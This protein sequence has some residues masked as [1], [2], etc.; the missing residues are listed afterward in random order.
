MQN[1]FVT[2]TKN[3]AKCTEI[4]IKKY[5]NTITVWQNNLWGQLRQHVTVTARC[6]GHTLASQTWHIVSA[7][8]LDHDHAR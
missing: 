1:F 2:I 5:H 7:L 8:H 6:D 4:V 3:N